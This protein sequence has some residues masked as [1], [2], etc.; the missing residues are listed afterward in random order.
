[1]TAPGV[2]V[3][4]ADDHKLVLRGV[5]LLLENAPGIAVVG[6][7][8]DGTAVVALVDRLAPD[9][10][11]TDLVMPGVNML[12]VL[13]QVARRRRTRALV[14]SMHDNVAYVA[15][16]L[17]RGAAGYVLKGSEV[18]ELLRAIRAV[19]G[20]ETFLG[21]PLSA[22]AVARYER[23]ASSNAGSLEPIHLLTGREREILHLVVEGRSSGEIGA[24]LGISQR[25]V[26]VH[27]ANMMR[28]LNL[29]SQADLIRCAIRSGLVAME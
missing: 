8:T 11:V 19:A 24:R 5:R 14:L 27:R 10:L 3:V 12:D 25:T 6:E 17:R 20:G 23:Q 16:A 2:T 29:H 26:E 21:R 18:D 1:M 7:T 13:E 4:I 28:K 22:A 15:Q 9:V